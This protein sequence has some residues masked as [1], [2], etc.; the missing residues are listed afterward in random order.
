[1]QALY[2]EVK[3]QK[4]TFEEWRRQMDLLEK[5]ATVAE[6]EN[7]KAVESFKDRSKKILEDVKSGKLTK[8]AAKE[9]IIEILPQIPSDELIAE[10]DRINAELGLKPIKPALDFE[11]LKPEVIQEADELTKSIQDELSRAELSFGKGTALYAD[12]AETIFDDAIKKADEFAN[13]METKYGKGTAMT[14]VQ[15][16]RQMGEAGERRRLP[17]S[18]ME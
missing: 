17:V 9:Q 3:A 12:A 8:G 7:L 15:L 10:M 2:D 4:M 6:Y 14:V 1:V 18:R 5:A 13:E 16:F 11:S